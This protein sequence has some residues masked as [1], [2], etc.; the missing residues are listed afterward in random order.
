M[1]LQ[2]DRPALAA[3]IDADGAASYVYRLSSA[4][5]NA[6]THALVEGA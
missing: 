1:F 6:A 5:R 4:L 3:D 2:G